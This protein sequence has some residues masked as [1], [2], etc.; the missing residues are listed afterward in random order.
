M[1]TKVL[2][3]KGT[4]SRQAMPSPH[5]DLAFPARKQFPLHNGVDGIEFIILAL[6]E[7][8]LA[9]HGEEQCQGWLLPQD[10]TL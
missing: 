8:A 7:L 3:D 9:V 10:L 5:P 1:A 4:K 2:W 6:L